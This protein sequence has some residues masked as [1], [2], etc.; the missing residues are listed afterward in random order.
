MK[1]TP[2]S[3]KARTLQRR[4]LSEDDIVSLTDRFRDMMNRSGLEQLLRYGI[5]PEEYFRFMAVATRLGERREAKGLDIKTVANR[6]KVP[7]YRL[8]D[9]ENCRVNKLLPD[10]LTAYVDYLGLKSWFG[11]WKKGNPEIVARLGLES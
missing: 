6:L 1:R 4:I 11:R 9:V 3:K 2:S 7:Q 8:R 5:D 10:V